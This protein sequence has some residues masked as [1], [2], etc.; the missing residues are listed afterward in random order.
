MFNYPKELRKNLEKCK[1]LEKKIGQ[2]RF[3]EISGCVSGTSAY[4]PVIFDSMFTSMTDITIHSSLTSFNFD[5][6]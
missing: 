6:L 3:Y 4:V 2:I 5:M 1:N